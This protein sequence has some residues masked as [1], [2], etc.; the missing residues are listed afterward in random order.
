MANNKLALV[1]FISMIIMF[2]SVEDG[3]ALHLSANCPSNSFDCYRHCTL[4]CY[5]QKQPD[6]G[7]CHDNCARICG[8]VP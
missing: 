4:K 7:P 6:H 5:Y 3:E 2:A 1:I 8:C